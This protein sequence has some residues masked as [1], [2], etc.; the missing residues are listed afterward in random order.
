MSQVLSKGSS[1]HFARRILRGLR[2]LLEVLGILP[3]RPQ[4][5]QEAQLARFRLYHT[6]FRKLLSANH[7]FLETLAEL[8]E[9]R[10]GIGF[11][12]RDYIKRKLLRCLADVHAMVEGI[13]T[14]SGARYSSLRPALERIT[15][16]LLSALEESSLNGSRDLILDLSQIRASLADLVGGKMANLGEAR[17]GLGLPTPD[18]FAVTVEGFRLFMEE[19][20]L[21]S[22][23][24]DRHLYLTSTAQVEPM[25]SEI[26]EKILGAQL[27][28]RLL[29]AMQ[30]ALERLARRLGQQPNLSVRSSAVGEDSSLSFAGQF[31]SVLNVSPKTLP[32]AYLEVVASLFSPEAIHYRMIHGIPPESAEMAVGVLAMIPAEAA[33]VVFSR[34]PAQPDSEEVLVQAVHGLGVSL[35]EGRVSPEM[36][37]VKDPSG[38]CPVIT[39]SASAQV[40]RLV[41]RRDSSLEE[42]P[43]PEERLGAQVLGNEDAL[44]LGR[45]AAELERHFGS[46]QDL[47]FAKG[48]HGELFL[49][50]TRPLRMAPRQETKAQA[51]EGFRVLLRAGETACPGVASGIAVRM[52]EDG[53]LESFP[54]GGILVARRSSPKFIR[55]MPRVRAIVTDA[56]ST[57][58]HMA[59]LAR[60]LGVPAL[61]NTKAA[62]SSIPPGMLVTVDASAGL[63]YEGEATPV[64][65]TEKNLSF[66][67]WKARAGHPSPELQLLERVLTHLSPLHLTDP[68]SPDFSPEHARTLHDLA[69]Y[70][71]EKSYEEMFGMG[72]RL[73]DMRPACYLL[74]VFLPIDLYILDLGGGLKELPTKG[75]VKPSQIASI[76]LQALLKGMLHEKIP[77]FG[78]RFMDLG[79]FFS[80]M[81]R[82]A[83][84]APEQERSFQDPCYALISDHYL[85]YTARVGYHFS[86]LDTYCSPTPN[87]N[88]VSLMF[89]GGAADYPRRARRARAIA[90]VLRHF[91]FSVSLAQDAVN[92]RLGKAS[93]EETREKLEMLG[94]LLQFFRQMDAAMATDQHAR[95]FQ[96]AFIKGDYD[97]SQTLGTPGVQA[98]EGQPGPA[99]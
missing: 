35:V 93:L 84:T 69:R 54:M 55:I 86:V 7:S 82:H 71:H 31:R 49:L 53:D 85:N 73:G 16:E 65:E 95:I 32:R 57:T 98:Q 58:G 24:Q 67:P 89:R 97:L 42:E 44:K 25:S 46:P 19:A 87:K 29:E 81:M 92:A 28:P 21:R 60:E 48:P 36:I 10:R 52:D 38:P 13:Q 40:T 90:E 96:E 99:P 34:D 50:Q 83:T 68:R 43:L 56:G 11:L 26:Q 5:D 77:R 12:D 33:G 22:W 91:G 94:R 39:R 41:M 2:T 62:T 20:G 70:I 66:A 88:Y 9:R 14:I 37:R 78:P 3:E 18:G 45:W 79:G 17:N 72:E 74:D 15:G 61:L 64:L 6:Q 4:V 30:A 51:V 23:I 80:V 76:P 27:P 59:S 47:E 8:E 63:V 75:K 1:P